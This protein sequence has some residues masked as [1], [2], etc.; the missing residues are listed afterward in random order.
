MHIY[1]SIYDTILL[2]RIR[3]RKV[4]KFGGLQLIQIPGLMGCYFDTAVLF[5]IFNFVLAAPAP[6]MTYSRQAQ[7]TAPR[8]SQPPV[9]LLPAAA[10]RAETPGK[11]F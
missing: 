2:R 11:Y 5:V 8:P 6:P 7:S 10:V 3:F 1:D 4:Y 9:P